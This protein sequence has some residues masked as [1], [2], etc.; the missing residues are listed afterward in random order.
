M[1]FL[2]KR[3]VSTRPG[4][5]AIH[6]LGFY[7]SKFGFKP[8]DY[9]VSRNCYQHTMALPLHNKMT[10]DDFNYVV[11]VLREIDKKIT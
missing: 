3:G 2:L 1:D 9:P 5:H 11:Y 6:M 10:I 4:T 7:K 8:S